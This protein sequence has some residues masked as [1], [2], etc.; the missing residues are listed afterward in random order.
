MLDEMEEVLCDLEKGKYQRD[1]VE[2]QNQ[3]TLSME[4]RGEY[5]SAKY[6]RFEDVPIV[7]PN[8]DILVNSI[9]FTVRLSDMRITCFV[10]WEG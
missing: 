4:S 8:G 2:A 10:F 6:I 1:Q 7:A 3:Q 9:N 5:I